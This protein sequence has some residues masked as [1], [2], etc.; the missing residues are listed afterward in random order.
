MTEADL[1]AVFPRLWHMAEDGSWPSIREHGLL[2]TLALLDRY[3][4]EGAERDAILDRRRPSAVRLGRTGLPGAVVRDQKPMTDGKLRACLADGLAPHDWYRLLNGKT[5]FWLD[6]DRLMRLLGARA[7]R[8]SPHIVI[9]VDTASLLAAHRGRVSLCPINSGSTLFTP[10]PRGL[11]TFQPIA[12]YWFDPR[13]RGRSRGRVPVELVVDYAV[14]DV[15]AH[16]LRV[17][18][19]DGI[20]IAT[21]WRR[22]DGSAP[23][24]A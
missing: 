24:S 10:Q 17:D 12:N 23:P 18:R 9:E 4:I 13:G 11:A 20:A 19:H 15:A 14:E 7:Y 3:G 2:S 22:E 1:V 16:A 6:R 5:F 21:A 8:G